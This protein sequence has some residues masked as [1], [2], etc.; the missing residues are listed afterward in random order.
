MAIIAP[1]NNVGGLVTRFLP[2]FALL[3][4]DMVSKQFKEP[5]GPLFVITI[6]KYYIYIVLLARQIDCNLEFNLVDST[7]AHPLFVATFFSCIFIVG[8]LFV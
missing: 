6:C 1:I 5:D 4:K 2:R 3:R 7:V 8:H